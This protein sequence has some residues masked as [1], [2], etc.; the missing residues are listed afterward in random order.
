MLRV[1]LEAGGDI[2][3]ITS[4]GQSLVHIVVM[5]DVSTGVRE[6]VELGAD[7]NAQDKHGYTALMVCANCYDDHST[8]NASEK[9]QILLDGGASFDIVNAKGFIA[10]QYATQRN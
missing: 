5:F 2:S 9:A 8:K 1:L 10:L 3:A 4:Q 7:L 6:V